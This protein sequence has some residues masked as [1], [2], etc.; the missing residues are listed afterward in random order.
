MRFVVRGFY[1]K[2]AILIPYCGS[3]GLREFFIAYGSL[4]KSYLMLTIAMLNGTFVEVHRNLVKVMI[5]FSL[6]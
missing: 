2:F 4:N 5:Y 6:S 1:G 3:R